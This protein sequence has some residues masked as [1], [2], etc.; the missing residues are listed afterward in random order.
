MLQKAEL[1]VG[2]L[3]DHIR[4]DVAMHAPQDLPTMVYLARAFELRANS[5][6]TMVPSGPQQH[7]RSLPLQPTVAPGGAAQLTTAAL[8]PIQQFCRLTPAE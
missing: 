5:I 6:M 3:L 2:D 7:A 1:F 8:S 4:V